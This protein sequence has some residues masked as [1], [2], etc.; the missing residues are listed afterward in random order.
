[1]PLREL[2]RQLVRL[3]KLMLGMSAVRRKKTKIKSEYDFFLS[4]L[5][6]MLLTCTWESASTVLDVN[7]K[8]KELETSI[9]EWYALHERLKGL[10]SDDFKDLFDEQF[11]A[12]LKEI[13]EKISEG[14]GHV[15]VIQHCNEDDARKLEQQQARDD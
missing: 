12:I 5:E 9:G 6:C 15:T 8:I 11:Q 7:E 3:E 10:F 4:R 2:M 1:M 14:K 13:S